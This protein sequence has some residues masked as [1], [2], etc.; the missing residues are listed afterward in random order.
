MTVRARQGY[1]LLRCMHR[2]W[3]QG[4]R[5]KPAFNRKMERFSLE[6]SIRVLHH[7]E[8][9]AAHTARAI[10][11]SLRIPEGGCVADEKSLPPPSVA[12]AAWRSVPSGGPHA[13]GRFEAGPG[14]G[15]PR[16]RV[17]R[18]GACSGELPEATKTPPEHHA[19]EGSGGDPCRPGISRPTLHRACA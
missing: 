15:Y 13:S 12:S 14:S 7:L 2:N 3:V 9:V 18:R 11:N 19:R 4:N 6:R 1:G 5:S 10:G 8:L 17:I 16:P